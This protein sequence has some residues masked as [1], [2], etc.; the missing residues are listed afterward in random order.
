MSSAYL[1]RNKL[2]EGWGTPILCY[3]CGKEINQLEGCNPESLAIHSL[4]DNHENWDPSNKTPAHLK[5]HSSFHSSQLQPTRNLTNLRYEL[6]TTIERLCID[7]S[8]ECVSPAEVEDTLKW[9]GAYKTREMMKVLW[10]EGWLTR[11]RRASYKLTDE[12]R[13]MLVRVE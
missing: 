2:I 8:L 9:G 5:C 10:R 12:G 4:D 3:F 1:C 11:L 7:R 13:Q 6:L